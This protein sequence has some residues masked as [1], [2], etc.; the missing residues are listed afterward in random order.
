MGMR[1][2]CT[3]PK[4]TGYKNYGGRG[5]TVCARWNV[6]ENFLDDMGLP[7]SGESLDRV[8]PNGNY[9]PSNC[10]WATMEVQSNNRRNSLK[11]T[12]DGETMSLAQ[13]SRKTGIPRTTLVRRYNDG[14]TPA[15]ILQKEHRPN[16]LE[17]ARKA[18]VAKWRREKSCKKGHEYTPETLYITPQGRRGC[19][20]CRLVNKRAFNAKARAVRHARGL[21]NKGRWAHL[22]PP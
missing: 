1:M 7:K 5:I 17:I 15:E 2:R 21:K 9:E 8:D 13:W 3:R 18:L 11:V 12:F 10:R 14:C 20:V 16:D 22:P 19:K 6:F 4:T